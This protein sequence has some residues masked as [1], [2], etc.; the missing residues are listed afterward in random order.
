MKIERRFTNEE[1]GAYGALA[2]RTTELGDPQPRRLGG[3]QPRGHRGARGLEP[4]GL[5]RAG[6]EVLPQGRRA[7]GAEA[8]QGEGGARRSSGA[9]SPTRRSS[10]SC[11]RR[12]ASAARPARG[13]CSTGW[14]GPGPTGAGRAATSRPRSTRRPTTTRCATCWRRRWARRTRR[15]GSTPGCTG[16]TASTGRG[17]GISTSTSSRA[18][19]CSRPSAYEHPQPHAC[20]I[21][22]VADDLVNEGGIMDLWTRE[23][24]LFKYGSGT[25]TNFS[26]APRRERAAGGRRQVV[27]ADELPEDRRPGGRARSSRAAPRGA[28][29]RW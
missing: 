17:R 18:S 2:F 11:P 27:G 14:P 5:G 25:G 20:F 16:P 21:Q 8:G 24:R 23:A 29:R 4:G 10:P 13:R 19:W 6:A 26:L 12:R 22:S 15:S 1:T 28:R 3:V 9:R 7:G